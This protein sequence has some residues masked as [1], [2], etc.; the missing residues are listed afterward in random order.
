MISLAVHQLHFPALG[1]GVVFP[2][3]FTSY[4]FVRLGGVTRSATSN[5]DWLI[6]LFS[7]VV[8]GQLGYLIVSSSNFSFTVT[9]NRD[10]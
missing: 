5:S 7:S 3:Q 4:V 2:A 1:I 6:A 8:I 10:K 9:K